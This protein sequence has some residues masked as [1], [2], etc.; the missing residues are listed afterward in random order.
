MAN[1]PKLIPA[2]TI[3]VGHC[4]SMGSDRVSTHIS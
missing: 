1:F 3:Y 2:F 4:L